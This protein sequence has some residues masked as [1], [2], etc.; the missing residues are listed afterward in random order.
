MNLWT[1]VLNL[2]AAAMM[3]TIAGATPK[4]RIF[5]STVAGVC[6]LVAWPPKAFGP[7]VN[8]YAGC[9][10]GEAGA[11]YLKIIEDPEN[12]FTV[13]L[14]DEQ[15]ARRFNGFI[16]AARISCQGVLKFGDTDM[17]KIIYEPTPK[18][19]TLE[20]SIG[21]IQRTFTPGDCRF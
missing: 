11:I 4:A 18:N 20:I 17:K 5:N 12:T 2:V 15:T 7:M 1:I 10:S 16:D 3:R 19:E 13:D 8:Y 21:L 6:F 14:E 9:P